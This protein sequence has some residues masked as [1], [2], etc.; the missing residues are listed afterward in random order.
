[1]ARGRTD[2]PNRAPLACQV[3]SK[4]LR[5]ARSIGR[6]ASRLTG[7]DRDPHPTTLETRTAIPAPATRARTIHSRRV[8]RLVTV[9][10]EKATTSPS[11]TPNSQSGPSPCR[12]KIRTRATTT[13]E[14]TMPSDARHPKQ[15]TRRSSDSCR[16]VTHADCPNR[17]LLASRIASTERHSADRQIWRVKRRGPMSRCSPSLA[18]WNGTSATRG[19]LG[20][21]ERSGTPSPRRWRALSVV[22]YVKAGRRRAPEAPI[23][24]YHRRAT[25]RR[26]GT[27]DLWSRSGAVR[28]FEECARSAVLR[29]QPRLSDAMSRTEKL[30]LAETCMMG[31]TPTRAMGRADRLAMSFG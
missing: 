20:S 12:P 15:P 3:V 4:E 19:R 18:P 6:S 13:V 17:A 28:G 21:A 8:R 31:M 24:C 30:V 26:S 7:T 1:M 14:R 11:K 9:T 5:G 2:C 29:C 27:D 22:L 25:A 16:S 10:T 23:W